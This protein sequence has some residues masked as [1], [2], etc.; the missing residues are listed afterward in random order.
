MSLQPEG[1]VN[2]EARLLAGDVELERERFDEAGRLLWGWRFFTTILQSSTRFES[3]ACVREAERP[4]K[5]RSCA[6]VARSVPIHRRINLTCM[7]RHC[8]R[9]PN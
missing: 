4:R 6:A 9:W 5:R 1:R 3:S 2:A 7:A 8:Q